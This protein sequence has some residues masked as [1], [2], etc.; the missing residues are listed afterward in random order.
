MAR[1]LT[2]TDSS[3]MVRKA[4]ERG[5][6]YIRELL[7]RRQFVRTLRGERHNFSQQP[8][9]WVSRIISTDPTQGGVDRGCQGAVPS[10]WGRAEEQY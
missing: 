4:L 5:L 1:R 9:T 10:M 6:C 3:R 8:A 7:C 2:T